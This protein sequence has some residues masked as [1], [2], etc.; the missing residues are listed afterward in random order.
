MPNRPH[1]WS[2]FFFIVLFSCS[3]EENN[4]AIEEENN[5]NAIAITLDITENTVLSNQE[6]TVTL[7][8]E[9]DISRLEIFL[10]DQNIENFL[11]PPYN[12]IL[13]IETLDEG[14]HKLKVAVYSNG[15]RVA[16]KTITVK[17]DNIGP[18]L[19]IDSI[20]ANE[21][22]CNKIRVSP[23]ISDIVSNVKSLA[24]FLDDILVSERDNS[25]DFSFILN[26]EELPAGEGN[27]KFISEDDH[28]N[29]SRDSIDIA[30]GEKIMAINFPKD[31]MRKGIEKIHIVI[32]DSDGNFIDSRTHSSGEIETLEFCSFAETNENSEFILTFI[33]DFNNTIFNFYVYSNLSKGML[34]NAINLNK[35]SGG[36]SPASLKLDVPFYEDSYQMRASGPWN[37][38]IYYNGK[39][40][41]HVSTKFSN[42]LATNKTF[43]SYFNKNI[44]DSYQWAWITDLQ[45]RTTLAPEDFTKSRVTAATFEIDSG[46]LSP[47]MKITGYENEAMYSARTGHLLYSDDLEG[48]TSSI[49]KYY[50]ADIFDYYTYSGQVANYTW[51]G[52]G[53]PPSRITIPD[54]SIDYSFSNGQVRFTG[55]PEYEVG[56][57]RLIGIRTGG[58]VLTAENPSVRVELIFDGQQ[59]E[60]ILP[61][62]PEGIFPS[63]VTQMFANKTFEIKQGAAE[64]YSA[65]STYGDYISKVLVPSVPFY[66]A[67]PFKERVFKSEGPQWLPTNEFPF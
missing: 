10:D 49:K 52:S 44:A 12:F 25:T 35:T 67:S 4:T 47:I 2:I 61:Q 53:K 37:S 20:A 14:E 43:I 41:G 65:F 42:E 32:S 30:I 28:G 9:I 19:S 38:L 11:A 8:T 40:S 54:A 29:I 59:N 57:I 33:H 48:P 58:A 6:I 55:L 56:R 66:I 26:P 62:I 17:I 31:F 45:S 15:K 1:F 21:L 13:D 46:F 51:E 27:L 16:S 23:R 34:G 60:V 3:S 5:L 64:N 36:L 18:Q 22:I 24:V 39:F 50:F 7:S 63:A